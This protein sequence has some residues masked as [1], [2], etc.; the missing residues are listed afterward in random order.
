MRKVAV[1]IT[2]VAALWLAPGAFAAWCG[3][4]ES[5]TDRLP[6]AV[7]AQQI[8]AV[9][10]V[11]ADAPDTFATN[12]SQ[13]TDDVAS[14]V[15]WWAGQDPTRIPRFDQALFGGTPC[16][17]ISFVRL[18]GATASYADMGANAA[19]QQIAQNLI[20]AGF[21]DPYKKYL[22]YFEGP[23]V[24]QDVCGVGA[25]DLLSG[26]SFAIVLTGGCPDVPTDTTATHELLHAL[27]AVPPG[28]PHCPAD[29]G[30]PCDSPTDVLYPTTDGSPLSTKVLD[31]NHDDYY[32]HSEPWSDVQ[33]SLW[34]HRLD[35]APVSLRISF[36]GAGAVSSEL[37]GLD[38]TAACST[39]WDP[40]ALVTLDAESSRSD[41]FVR[42]RGACTGRGTC[43]VTL[44]Q[45]EA[46]TATFGPLRIPLRVS[47]S[48]KGKVTC[49]PA[50]TKSFTA[51]GTLR[52]RAVAAKGWKFAGWGGACTGVRSTCSPATDYALKV[53]A[54]FKKKR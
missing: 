53:T 15:S 5:S 7:T 40:G 28:D 11:P 4:G 22:V 13:V 17:D 29:P 36:A 9:V 42:W 12:A 1:A 14:M 24:E 52:L 20:S 39:Q 19:F 49:S 10:A 34:L 30:H 26:P 44:A 43:L 2:I 46:V 32:A 33:D 18:P 27:G 31:Y 6:D 35:E 37:P 8:H 23:S 38:C 51:G 48:G 16:L 50:C 21:D 3:S 41:R 25:G 47:T 45:S 54:R